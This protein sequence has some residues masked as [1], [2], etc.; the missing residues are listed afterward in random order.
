LTS[1]ASL[2]AEEF[3]FFRALVSASGSQDSH[4]S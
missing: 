3:R 4:H 1:V 2:A